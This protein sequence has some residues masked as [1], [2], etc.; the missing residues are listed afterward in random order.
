VW[1]DRGRKKKLIIALHFQK[2]DP[3]AWRCD[4]CRRQGLD[5][6]RRCAWL[7]NS[8]PSTKP[9]WIGGTVPVYQCPKS[10]ITADSL[11]W[12]EGY[13]QWKFAGH[14]LNEIAARDVDAYLLIE[15][16]SQRE[17]ENG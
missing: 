2:S 16:E 8:R 11:Y 15:Q 10:L 4:V 6:S 9:I 14:E 5:V 12:I 3:A 1:P 7:A 13:S 17:K